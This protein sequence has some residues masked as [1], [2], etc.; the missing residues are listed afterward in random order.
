MSSE[1]PVL[2]RFQADPAEWKAGMVHSDFRVGDLWV[3]PSH[4][5]AS[6]VTAKGVANCQPSLPGSRTQLFQTSP[7]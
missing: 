1:A 5:A 2:R 7:A 6:G 4:A 3:S